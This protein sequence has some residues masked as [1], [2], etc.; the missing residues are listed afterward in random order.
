ML[1]HG[2]VRNS[3]LA[4]NWNR[5]WLIHYELNIVCP[6]HVHFLPSSSHSAHYTLNAKCYTK[7][8]E[9]NK[10]S[11][12]LVGALTHCYVENALNVITIT[13]EHSRMN[14]LGWIL[15]CNFDRN[16]D[17]SW[18]NALRHSHRII[19]RHQH[20]HTHED[21]GFGLF[22]VFL[23]RPIWWLVNIPSRIFLP[24]TTSQLSRDVFQLMVFTRVCWACGVILCSMVWLLGFVRRIVQFICYCWCCRAQRFQLLGRSFDGWRS[25]YSCLFFWCVYFR[26]YFVFEREWKSN[27]N[28]VFVLSRLWRIQ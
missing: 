21:G 13:I 8:C 2:I 9:P 28:G 12:S 6:L 19:V 11:V 20:S 10:K 14:L 24:R 3:V 26:V 18:A 23:L 4:T 17:E 16:S 1:Y 22:L 15:V 25:R 7:C 27:S 5:T